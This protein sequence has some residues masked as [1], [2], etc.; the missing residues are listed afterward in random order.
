MLDV[1][2]VVLMV[3]VLAAM[4]GLVW[5]LGASVMSAGSVFGLVISIAAFLYLS[6]ALFR[7]ENL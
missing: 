6:Y 1:Y 4:V 2:S 3:G 5:A 7:G